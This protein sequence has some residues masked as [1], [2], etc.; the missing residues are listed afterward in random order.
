MDRSPLG[1]NRSV[2][3]KTVLNQFSHKVP[4][5]VALLPSSAVNT[6]GG[7][8]DGPCFSFAEII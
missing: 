5:P 1:E 2:P 7:L 6:K 8:N 3:A 4:L